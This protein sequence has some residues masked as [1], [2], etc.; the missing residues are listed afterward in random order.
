MQAVVVKEK[1]SLGYRGIFGYIQTQN[2]AKLSRLALGSDSKPFTEEK[3]MIIRLSFIRK[4]VELCSY[5]SLGHSSWTLKCFPVLPYNSE[6]FRMCTYGE[7]ESLQRALSSR[8]VSPFVTDYRGRTLIHFAAMNAH[9]EM[10]QLLIRLGVDPD[11]MDS[12]GAKALYTTAESFREYSHEFSYPVS[13]AVDTVRVLTA[14][15]DHVTTEDI[16]E[17]FDCYCGPPQGAEFMLSHETFLDEMYGDD[18]TVF[19]LL[20]MALRQ[21]GCG[22][23]E[24]RYFIKRLLSKAVELHVGISRWTEGG[25]IEFSTPL[26]E[27]FCFNVTPEDGDSAGKDWMLMLEEEGHDVHGYLEQEMALHA[28][29]QFLTFPAEWPSSSAIPR[30]LIF[31]WSHA[32][33]VTWDWWIEPNSPASEVRQELKHLSVTG[34]D[35]FSHYWAL[36]DYWPFDYSGWANVCEPYKYTKALDDVCDEWIAWQ[37]RTKLGRS[38][39]ARRFRRKNSK[40]PYLT[41]VYPRL[42]MP[43]AWTE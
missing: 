10:C 32:S 42:D 28:G 26:D 11:Q 22:L 35:E 43:G 12:Y 19:S 7:I 38:R 34:K 25:P 33:T 17:F 37:E 29:Q 31:D 1:F 16:S 9:T 36:G 13:A 4:A 39:F 18:Q 24:W 23:K 8:E 15:Q 41:G 21:Y 40:H 30:R 20:C 2:K 27:L 3:R 5:S 14:A 6:V